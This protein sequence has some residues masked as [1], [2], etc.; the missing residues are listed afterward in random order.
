MIYWWILGIVLFAGIVF[1]IRMGMKEPDKID[2]ILRINNL[3][4]KLSDIEKQKRDS[5]A[6]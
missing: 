1:L 4:N 5:L 2:R 3:R 6:L